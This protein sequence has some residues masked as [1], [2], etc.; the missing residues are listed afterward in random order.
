MVGAIGDGV[1][2]S[3]D[4]WKEE[5]RTESVRKWHAVIERTESVLTTTDSTDTLE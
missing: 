3:A 5:C 1:T 2:V 4:V